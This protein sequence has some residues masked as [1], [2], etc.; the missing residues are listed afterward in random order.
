LQASLR[1]TQLRVN[2]GLVAPVVLL[3]AQRNLNEAELSL[4]RARA[5][6]LAATV[7]LFKALGGGWQPR[8]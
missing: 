7:D 1:L 6:R 4:V 8:S 3:D 5:A 2:A